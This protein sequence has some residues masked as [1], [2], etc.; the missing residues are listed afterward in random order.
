MKR[1]ATLGHYMNAKR[2]MIARKELLKIFFFNFSGGK[3]NNF[4]IYS[5][6][7]GLL[8]KLLKNNYN[9]LLKRK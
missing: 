5:H 6:Y 9:K 3:A 8:W 4:T 1:K 7:E 2:M